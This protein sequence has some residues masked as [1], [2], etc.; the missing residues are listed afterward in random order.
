M[1]IIKLLCR[2]TGQLV[3]I[4]VFQRMNVYEKIKKIKLSPLSISRD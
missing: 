2:Q 4:G 1:K 3:K